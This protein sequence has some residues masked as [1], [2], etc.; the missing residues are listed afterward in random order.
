MS[1]ETTLERWHVE[2]DGLDWPK[3]L[4]LEERGALVDLTR[5]ALARFGEKGASLNSIER[6]VDA[7]NNQRHPAPVPIFRK[8]C[9]WDYRYACVERALRAI[10]AEQRWHAK[11]E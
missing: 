5:E 8:A 6:M 3:G 4:S 10:D 11:K 2:T 7:L 9:M 1:H